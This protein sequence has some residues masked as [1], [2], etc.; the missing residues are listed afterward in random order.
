MRISI[1]AE[2]GG[3][4]VMLL[5]RGL[6]Y[7]C[8]IAYSAASPRLVARLLLLFGKYLIACGRIVDVAI[9]ADRMAES[10]EAAPA[11]CTPVVARIADRLFV[12][13]WEEGCIIGRG[14]ETIADTRYRLIA[15]LIL[16]SRGTSVLRMRRTCSENRRLLFIKQMV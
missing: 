14:I 10:A 16:P 6:Y 11:N 2:G 7:A 4:L 15:S 1:I 12:G 5:H 3:K 13:R 9:K 8:R